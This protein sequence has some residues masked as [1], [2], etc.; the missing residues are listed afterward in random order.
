[1]LKEKSITI[2][3]QRPFK[4]QEEKKVGRDALI[5]SDMSALNMY[6]NL[7]AYNILEVTQENSNK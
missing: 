6:T 1:M 2:K 3:L 5:S 4:Q 7:Q